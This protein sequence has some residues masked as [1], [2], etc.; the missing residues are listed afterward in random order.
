M[1]KTYNKPT[2]KHFAIA[3]IVPLSS[4]FVD[5]GDKGYF[6][7]KEQHSFGNETPNSSNTDIWQEAW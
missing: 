6:D 2:I 3:S 7:A 4:S 5:V 1:K